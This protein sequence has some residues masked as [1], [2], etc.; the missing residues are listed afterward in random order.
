MKLTTQPHGKVLAVDAGANLLAIVLKNN[1]PVSYSHTASRCGTCR[2]K[3][4][5]WA[6]QKAAM[7]NAVPGA[8]HLA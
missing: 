5:N 6:L 7:T 8:V 4:L 1:V 3:F 2:W